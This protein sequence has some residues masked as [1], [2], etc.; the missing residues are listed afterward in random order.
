ML[1]A[2]L[3]GV[4]VA[5]ALSLAPGPTWA[6]PGEM[7]RDCERCPE[8]VE[9]PAGTF[10][11]G[12]APGTPEMNLTGRSRA[13]SPPVTIHIERPFALG[14]T[15]VTRAQYAA[16]VAATGF[17]P[18]V[19]FCRVWDPP[20]QRFFDA[21]GVTWRD[22]G[23]GRP[24]P[25]DAP[26]TCVGWPDAMAYVRWL[27]SLTG[28]PYRLPSEAE[29]EYAARAGTTSRR[30]WGNSSG[31]G[32]AYA[33]SYDLTAREQYPLAWRH[34]SCR[35]GFAD[36]APVGSLKPN[37]FGL[38]DMIGNVWEGVADCFTTSKVGRPKD[39]RP[40]VWEDCG[41]RAL[42]GG[43]W[44]TGPERSRSAYPAGDPPQDRYSFLGFRVARELTLP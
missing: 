4:V 6:A 37:A 39:Q 2:A 43:G 13:E 22:G 30:P 9:I 8:L 11:M 40:W 42:R 44:I 18:N 27:R 16:F 20:N 19:A 33:N 15:E 26:V 24:L 36:L 29:W 34:I 1:Q 28:Q 23:V 21:V 35:D 3:P 5:I 7:L 38:H 14:R 41:D 25:D 10:I 32:C 17:N 12:S 31:E